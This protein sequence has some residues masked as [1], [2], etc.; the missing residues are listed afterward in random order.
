MNTKKGLKKRVSLF[1]SFAMI[2]SGLMVETPV[3]AD[4]V[5][6]TGG[7]STVA[8]DV[9]VNSMESISIDKIDFND[10]WQFYLATRTPSVIGGNTG[11][12]F[13][14]NGLEDAGDYTTDQIVDPSF[15]DRS[16]RTLSVPH[17]WSI[18]GE[19]VSSGTSNAQAYLQGGLGWY[20]KSFILSESMKDK[21]RIAIDFEGVYQN[22]DV[23]VNGKLVGNH[24]SGYTGFTF[25]ITDYVTFGND[26][27]NVIVIKVQNMSS[28]GRW[29]TG[30]GIV[31]PVT[32]VVTGETRFIRNGVVITTPTLEQVV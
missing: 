31:R 27:P 9:S 22:S 18:E 14:M 4:H 29:Y 12:N 23:Y 20:R 5:V 1:L 28:S 19:K 21:N 7:D 26:E 25:D 32:L 15:D 17:D 30:S 24:P 8:K 2:I 11:S 13:A 3:F 16:W 6:T 10:D